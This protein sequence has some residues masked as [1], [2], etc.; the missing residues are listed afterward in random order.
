MPASQPCLVMLCCPLP[1][2]PLVAACS[3]T[4][5]EGFAGDVIGLTNPGAFAIGDTI[6]SGPEVSVRLFSNA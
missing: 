5:Q 2:N 6:F 1:G 4:V 3:A